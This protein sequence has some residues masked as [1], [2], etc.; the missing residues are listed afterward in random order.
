MD[1][2]ERADGTRTVPGFAAALLAIAAITYGSFLLAP[3]LSPDIDPINSYAS[4]LSA[5]DQPYNAVYSAGDGITGFLTIIAALTALRTLPRRPWTTCG[6]FTLALFGLSAIGDAVFPMECAPTLSTTCALRERAG[7]VS[8]S[9]QFHV[10]TSTGVITMAICSMVVLSL[11]AR[12]HHRWPPLARYGMPL[13]MLDV[14]VSIATLATMLLG[15]WLGLV[16]R[17]QIGLLMMGL[18][19]IAWAVYADH[20][21]ARGSPRKRLNDR[22]PQVTA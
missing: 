22:H 20:H 14:V 17:V 13:A 18:L 9:H 12:R 19:L 11:A 6:W 2:G 16:Q 7:Q 1:A 4:E 10:V 21:T 3:F 5:T 8:F 15:Q